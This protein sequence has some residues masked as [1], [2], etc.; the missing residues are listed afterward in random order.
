MGHTSFQF[1]RRTL[2]KSGIASAGA[3]ALGPAFLRQAFA[4]GPVTVGK[5]PYGPLQPFDANGIALPKGFRSREIARGNSIVKGGGV[6]YTYHFATDGQA[7]FPTL[8]GDGAPEVAPECPQGEAGRGRPVANATRARGA[9]AK[10]A[11][12][13]GS[14]AGVRPVARTQSA[15]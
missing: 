11:P 6:P 5:S 10:A 1:D 4:H 7:T 15:P 14:G 13:R 8:G 9:R 2:L 3:L 12:R